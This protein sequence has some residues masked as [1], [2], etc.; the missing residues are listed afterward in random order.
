MMQDV[1]KCLRLFKYGHQMKSNLFCMIFF[2]CLGVLYSRM[3]T[4]MLHQCAMYIFLGFI[5]PIQSW[6][7]NLY[8][9]LVASSPKRRTVEIYAMDVTQTIGAIISSGIFLLVAYIAKEFG[10]NEPT[11]ISIVSYETSLVISGL[12]IICIMAFMPCGYKYIWVP[13][14]ICTVGISGCFVLVTKDSIRSFLNT[15]LQG[16]TGLAILLFLLEVTAGLVLAGIFRR[17]FYRKDFNKVSM[18]FVS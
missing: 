4:D 16:R 7:S 18:R 12:I 15:L 9:G 17:V 1:K 10:Q 13:L 14:I 3:G 8:A 11:E 6:H 2:I 5:L